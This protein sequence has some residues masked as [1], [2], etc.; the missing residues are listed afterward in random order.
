MGLLKSAIKAG[1]VAKAIDFA[2]RPENQAK[3][4]QMISQARAKK[5][6]AR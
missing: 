2:R 1:I 5:A 3:V 4:K 6:P